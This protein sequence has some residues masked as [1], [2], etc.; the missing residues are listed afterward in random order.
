MKK[1]QVMSFYEKFPKTKD[2]QV[3]IVTY[4]VLADVYGKSLKEK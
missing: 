4:N 1:T 3:S 2:C